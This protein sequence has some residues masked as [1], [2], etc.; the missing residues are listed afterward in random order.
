MTEEEA[1]IIDKNIAK[2]VSKYVRPAERKISSRQLKVIVLF[3]KLSLLSN[4][5]NYIVSCRK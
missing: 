1:S 5:N 4:V 2:K 3:A